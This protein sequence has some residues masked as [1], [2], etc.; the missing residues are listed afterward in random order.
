M[1]EFD[2]RLQ[3]S[4]AT[5]V[6]DIELLLRRAAASALEAAIGAQAAAPIGRTLTA[7]GA[8]KNR[9][10]RRPKRPLARGKKR[11]PESLARLTG[12]LHAYIRRHKG[13]GVEAIGKGMGISTRELALPM[14]KLLAERRV[15]ARGVKRATRYF[16][17]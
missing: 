14:K 2:R 1:R 17:G 5:F 16:P 12:A 8:P 6:D 13:L 11:S 15:A 10:E 7:R 3:T 9:P 4:L